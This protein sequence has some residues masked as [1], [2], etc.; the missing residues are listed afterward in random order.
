VLETSDQPVLPLG[1]Q[2]RPRP[3]LPPSLPAVDCS[4]SIV[5]EL[6]RVA[7][8]PTKKTPH[9]VLRRSCSRQ[10]GRGLGSIRIRNSRKR[11]RGVY[12]DT[13]GVLPVKLSICV[14]PGF[15]LQL[16]QCC[17]LRLSVLFLAS[18]S[19]AESKAPRGVLAASVPDIRG[20]SRKHSDREVARDAHGGLAGDNQPSSCEDR[21]RELRYPVLANS[22]SSGLEAARIA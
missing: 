18:Q 22:F 9:G 20:G 2:R 19:K 10:R 11:S 21:G 3:V 15:N 12:R 4:S 16:F 13:K 8:E 5:L 14:V 17:F 6:G 7:Q 1:K